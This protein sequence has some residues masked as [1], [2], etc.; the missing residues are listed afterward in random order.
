MSCIGYVVIGVVVTAAIAAVLWCCMSSKSTRATKLLQSSNRSGARGRHNGDRGV[1]SA[2]NVANIARPKDADSHSNLN[3]N[4]VYAAGN[5]VTN[6]KAGNAFRD[7]AFKNLT[8]NGDTDPIN[9]AAKIL[10]KNSAHKQ[11]F[12]RSRMMPRYPQNDR[13]VNQPVRGAEEL[14]ELLRGE[15]TTGNVTRAAALKD[16]LN[17]QNGVHQLV[18]IS[19][20]MENTM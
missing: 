15:V 1:S 8:V 18:G 2:G 17:P 3:T 20:R 5:A 9:N 6:T 7:C 10:P 19:T 4:K 14:H 12:I 13:G 11:G 16:K